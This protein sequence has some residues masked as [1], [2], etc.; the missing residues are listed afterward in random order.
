MLIKLKTSLSKVL[1]ALVHDTEDSNAVVPIRPVFV[2]GMEQYSRTVVAIL[3]H[4]SQRIWFR[5]LYM[6][7]SQ[8]MWVNEWERIHADESML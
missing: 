7:F 3:R 1:D 8:H 2:A 6:A 4:R 5:W